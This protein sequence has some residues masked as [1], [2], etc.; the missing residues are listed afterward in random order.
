[1]RIVV[2]KDNKIAR[3]S[4]SGNRRAPLDIRVSKIKWSRSHRVTVIKRKSNLLAK[5]T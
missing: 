2:N 3:P 4:L 5:L 1:M